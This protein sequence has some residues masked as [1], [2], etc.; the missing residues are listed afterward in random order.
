MPSIEKTSAKRKSKIL[1]VVAVLVMLLALDG[2]LLGNASYY[3]KW[4]Q[5]GS[6]PYEANPDGLIPGRSPHYG[7]TGFSFTHSQ[8]KF[9]TVAE[10]EKAGY[11]DMRKRNSLSIRNRYIT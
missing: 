7:R 4:V 10:T 1:G 3:T 8:T 5:C 9:C 11:Y 2:V 6:K